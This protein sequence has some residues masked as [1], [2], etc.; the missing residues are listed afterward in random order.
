[1]APGVLSAPAGTPT[2]AMWTGGIYRHN[3]VLDVSLHD[4]GNGGCT[5][6]NGRSHKGQA[7]SAAFG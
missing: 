4:V 2:W 3:L 5:E 1:M 7:L 6:S